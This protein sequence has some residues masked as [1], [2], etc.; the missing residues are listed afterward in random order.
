[1]CSGFVRGQGI[2][3]TYAQHN[4]GEFPGLTF[5]DAHAVLGSG[6]CSGLP[7][8]RHAGQEP[9]YAGHWRRDEGNKGRALNGCQARLQSMFV[10]GAQRNSVGHGREITSEPIQPTGCDLVLLAASASGRHSAASTR[11]ITR[12]RTR[13]RSEH[14]QAPLSAMDRC[15]CRIS[16]LRIVILDGSCHCY[17]LRRRP[18]KS[19]KSRT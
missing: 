16:Y 10:L 14:V 8:T 17:Y 18:C 6:R 1:M 3:S 5:F 13:R 12:A 15:S 11:G 2:Q 4:G 7:V 9:Q 19:S